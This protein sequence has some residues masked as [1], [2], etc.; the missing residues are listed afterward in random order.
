MSLGC[1]FAQGLLRQLKGLALRAEGGVAQ[2]RAPRLA[3][4]AE[5]ATAFTAAI[6]T[7]VSTPFTRAAGI[8][9]AKARLAAGSAISAGTAIAAQGHRLGFFHAGAVIAAHRHHRLGGARGRRGCRCGHV[10]GFG[11]GSCFARSLRCG[12]GSG[13]GRGFSRWGFRC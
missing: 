3:A 12:L 11:R 1:Q 5:I 10:C 6:A 13:L 7:T 2:A 9:V 4:V 8:A